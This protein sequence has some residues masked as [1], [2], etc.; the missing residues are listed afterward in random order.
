VKCSQQ[1]ITE[2]IEDIMSS[3]LQIYRELQAKSHKKK[4][5]SKTAQKKTNK[6]RFR[7]T[8]TERKVEQERESIF[9]LA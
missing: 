7:D 5:I 2:E 1:R 3:A 9:L 6:N 8:L 4:H